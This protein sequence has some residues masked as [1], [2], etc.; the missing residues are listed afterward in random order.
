MVTRTRLKVTLYIHCLSGLNA[1]ECHSC[2]CGAYSCF[3]KLNY[4]WQLHL[5]K[6]LGVYLYSEGAWFEYKPGH[7]ISYLTSPSFSSP[8]GKYHD[9]IS[10]R[11][12]TL[13]TKCFPIHC[14]PTNT[15]CNAIYCTNRPASWSSGQGLWLLIKRSRVRFPVLPWEFFLAGKDF[16]G[17]H[18]LGS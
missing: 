3:L 8:P 12:R 9:G 7:R 17:D 6:Q 4:T 5:N 15:K 18:G 13:T 11:P 16:R 2:I 10:V 14:F 1:S